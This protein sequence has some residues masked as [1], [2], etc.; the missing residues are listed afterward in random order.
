[1]LC[2]CAAFVYIFLTSA[3][4]FADDEEPVEDL[5]L[6]TPE[7]LASLTSEPAYLVGG[8][9]SPMSGQ[10]VLRQID[11]T[12]N[13]AQNIVLSRTYIPP[14][15]PCSFPRHKEYQGEYDKK[16][17][18]EHLV[19]NYKGW[20]IYPHVRLEI[21]PR[22]MVVRLAEPSGMTMDFRLT[23]QN[24]STS[25][26]AS[27]LYAVSNCAGD[28]PSG[29]HDI[30]NTR[31]SLE[32]GGNKVFVFAT[33]GTTRIYQKKT[34]ASRSSYLYLLEKEILENGKV[35]RY[36]Y[37]DNGQLRL[38]E[39]LDPKE[40]YVYATLRVEGN[41]WSGHTR[42]ISSSGLAAE[43]EYQRRPVHWKIKEKIKG[44]GKKKRTEECDAAYPPL[45]TS[46]ASP[47][48][49]G[50]TLDYGGN[51]LLES[52]SGR[53]EIFKAVNA[54]YGREGLHYKVNK[55]LLPVGPGDAFTHVFELSYQPPIPGQAEGTT[56]VNNLDGTSTVYHFSK[57]LLTTSIQYFGADGNLKKVKAFLWDQRQ[58]LQA[59]EMR[60]GQ[61][62]L[63]YRKTFEYDRFGNP[64]VET[65][66]GNLT[67][68]G[69]V[70]SFTT[71]RKFSE[72]GRNLLLKEEREEWEGG[73]LLLSSKY[74]SAYIEINQIWRS[75]SSAGILSVR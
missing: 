36:S 57:N 58:W 72:E 35:L 14:Y 2:R 52:Y 46:V 63:L 74:S 40:R 59:L 65:F 5:F 41:P 61:S 43:F 16:N 32:E 27:S 29:R 60:D 28:A 51:I 55:L 53:N 33:E 62:N 13:G 1:M 10:P 3:I 30:R 44:K 23:G 6:S 22:L 18:Y 37:Y 12:V 4:V 67:G 75:D 38:V 69:N 11:L 39:S 70:E 24:Y 42:F 26:Y 8:V 21:D 15:I 34:M 66:A 9:I 19:S 49:R 54:G 31:I 7:Q 68:E 20:Q 73:L 17:L 48:F 71:K 50:E 45:L 56:T 64:V 25:S 47:I